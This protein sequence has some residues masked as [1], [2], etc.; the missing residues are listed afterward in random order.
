[1][2]MVL[3]SE[4]QLTEDVDFL[5]AQHL[6]SPEHDS[7]APYSIGSA[8]ELNELWF[9]RGLKCGFKSVCGNQVHF[10]RV[11]VRSLHDAAKP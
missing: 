3:L 5:F 1:M 2:D 6:Q 10:H 8:T 7:T 11:A 4:V 9:P